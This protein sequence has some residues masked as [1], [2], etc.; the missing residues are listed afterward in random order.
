MNSIDM[1][2][3]GMVTNYKLVYTLY[4]VLESLGVETKSIASS[5]VKGPP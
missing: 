2:V 3:N 5:I 1:C 4:G